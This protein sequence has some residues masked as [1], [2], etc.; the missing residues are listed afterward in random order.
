MRFIGIFTIIIFFIF[1]C[2]FLL[3]PLDDID[4]L[5]L[6]G[7]YVYVETEICSK[8]NNGNIE[9]VVPDYV[10]NYMYNDEYII[11]KQHPSFVRANFYWKTSID[12]D[13]IRM[14]KEK[15]YEMKDCYWIII[16]SENIVFGPMSEQDFNK[17]CK[18]MNITIKM[19]KKY[20][21]QYVR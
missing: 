1:G 21:S 7:H 9:L 3:M 11:A 5:E 16:V 20:E 4:V 12:R 2:Y 15:C 14:L 8:D 6:S 19:D 17:K 13:S 10:V 18:E